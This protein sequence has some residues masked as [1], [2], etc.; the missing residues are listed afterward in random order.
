[1]LIVKLLRKI[2]P[3]ALVLVIFSVCLS[4]SLWAADKDDSDKAKA[5]FSTNCKSCHGVDGSGTPIGKSLNVP[6]LRSDA[7]QQ[8]SDAQLTEQISGGKGNMPAFK[9][10]L[11]P[12][13]IQSLVRYVRQLA[14]AKPS[15]Q[16]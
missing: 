2:A 5:A 6:D 3:L 4:R 15:T 9:N 11:T 16:K 14:A 1:M 7:V 10:S 13:Q 12:D 8:R